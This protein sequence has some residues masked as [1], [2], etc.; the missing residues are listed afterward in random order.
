ME[1]FQLL[2]DEDNWSKSDI[3]ASHMWSLPGI[4]CPYC[5]DIWVSTGLA[6]PTVETPELKPTGK[7]TGAVPLQEFRKLTD[8]IKDRLSPTQ[9][10]KACAEFGPLIGNAIG[11]VGDFAW[12]HSWYLLIREERLSQLEQIG[13]K[14]PKTSVPDLLFQRES[15]TLLEFEIEPLASWD[16]KSLKNAYECRE[17]GFFRDGLPG[18]RFPSVL[19]SSLPEHADLFRVKQ[20]PAFILC[21]EY[22]VEKV[23]RLKMSNIKF[24]KMRV[25]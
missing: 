15:A 19:R 20:A 5:G 2:P 18:N 21:N 11:R 6:Y 9:L 22:F 1:I 10:L 25:S 12:V 13:F 23:R 4:D 8:S 24:K 7:S 14:S 17:C 16:I 3:S